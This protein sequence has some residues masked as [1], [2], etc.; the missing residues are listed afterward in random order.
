MC[1]AIRLSIVVMALS[2]AWCL[3]A[4]AHPSLGESFSFDLE[5]K[6]DISVQFDQK[7][8][9]NGHLDFSQDE[10][11]GRWSVQA[12]P[13]KYH[14]PDLVDSAGLFVDR[15]G[16]LSNPILKALRKGWLPLLRGVEPGEDDDEQAY[17]FEFATPVQISQMMNG[18][19]DDDSRDDD[20]DDRDGDG[21]RDDDDRRDSDSSTL[22]F[23]SDIAG[24][25][26]VTPTTFYQ[27][28]S[29]DKGAKSLVAAGVR[30][31]VVASHRLPSSSLR[32]GGAAGGV[33]GAGGTDVPE[34][35]TALLLLPGLVLISMIRRRVRLRVAAA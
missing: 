7:N 6:F 24:T 8:P 14:G 26:L 20:G 5:K 12:T 9:K 19:W 22:S 3:P 4:T 21:R 29:Q 33:T 35:A 2:G 30:R 10:D 25:N 11:S 15:S 16:P 34:P 13:S 17:V 18:N 23:Y 32:T 31:I 27:N 28:S 1:F